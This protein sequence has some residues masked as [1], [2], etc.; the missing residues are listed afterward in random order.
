FSKGI[1]KSVIPNK[2]LVI[3]SIPRPKAKPVYSSGS[4][5]QFCNTL[6][7]T[8]PAPNI[9]IQPTP[10]Q[11]LQPL[12]S[13][14]GQEASASTLGSVNGKNEGRNLVRVFSPNNSFI[15]ALR[16]PLR[17]HILIPLSTTSPSIW[18]NIGE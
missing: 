10:L 16:V 8:I 13:Q 18:W 12:P 7:L 5:L 15:N 9:S 4:I 17:S 1:L 14:K 6:G 2:I 11:T 3:R